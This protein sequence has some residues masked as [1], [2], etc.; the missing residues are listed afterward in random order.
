MTNRVSVCPSVCNATHMEADLFS[1][2]DGPFVRNINLERP[3]S[4][5]LMC[6]VGVGLHLYRSVS[7]MT[8]RRACGPH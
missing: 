2:R 5:R 4:R 8:A 7:L 3:P 6:T 1:Y